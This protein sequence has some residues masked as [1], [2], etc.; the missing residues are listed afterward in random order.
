MRLRLEEDLRE[1]VLSYLKKNRIFHFRIE[2]PSLSNYPDLI[3]C[4][5]GQ[6][7]AVELKRSENTKA[8]LGQ[9]KIL[10]EINKAE[11]F[12][13]VIGSLAQLEKLL[14]KIECYVDYFG[15][16]DESYEQY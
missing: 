15:E 9:L 3:L 7:V 16:E 8:R 6:F 1:E 10:E 2:T 12:G 11:G 4:F 13:V 5:R 14:K